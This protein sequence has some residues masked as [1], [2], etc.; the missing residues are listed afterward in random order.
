MDFPSKA[1][2]LRTI[3]RKNLRGIDINPTA[4]HIACFSL[5][6]AYL[7][8]FDPRSIR[9]HCKT[10]G[11]F[12]PNLI[13]SNKSTQPKGR[14]EHIP[15][16]TEA[17]FLT[18]ET[19]E[20]GAYD[21]IISNPPW[22][23]GNSESLGRRF[24]EVAPRHLKNAAHGGF[25]LPSRILLNNTAN[26]FQAKWLKHISIEKVV[27]LADF[28]NVLFD[29]AK[30]PCL[31]IRFG[32]SPMGDDDDWIEYV[33]PKA[34]GIEM[35]N[36]C[37]T[38]S[39]GDQ[40]WLSKKQL[41]QAIEQKKA[42]IFWKSH[43]WG[44][45]RDQK[46]LS[47][48]EGFPRLNDYAGTPKE[49]KKG[50]KRWSTGRGFEPF[51]AYQKGKPGETPQK[52]T[53]DLNDL[54]IYP[55][56]LEQFLFVPK[57]RN[58][59]TFGERLE[60]LGALKNELRR[61]PN[62][63][64]FEPPLI[65]FNNGYTHFAFIDYPVRFQHTLHVIAGKSAD[66]DALLFLT[67]YL[68]SK[69]GYYFIFHTSANIGTER[70][71]AQLQEV[72][73]IPFFLPDSEVASEVSGNTLK[74]CADIMRRLKA[75]L[76]RQWS[77]M[78]PEPSS[79][80]KLEADSWKGRVSQWEAFANKETEQVMERTINPLIYEYF[81]LIDQEIALVEDTYNIL[82]NSITPDNLGNSKGI[83]QSLSEIA[84]REY[85]DQLTKTLSGWMSPDSK[86][87]INAICRI[88]ETLGLACVELIQS[89]T[90]KP[91]SVEEF[92]EKEALSYLQLE[93]ASTEERGSLRY[94]RSIR[95]FDNGRIR[96]YKPARLGFWMRSTAIN[97][98]AALHAEI[99]G[100]GGVPR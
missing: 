55:K 39:P 42:T 71:K 43:F 60:E 1:A 91:I 65:L 35:R 11:K 61:K 53:W 45:P 73:K 25:L 80:F 9:Q 79:E 44:T 69:L 47:A 21:Y 24:M 34:Y 58:K 16:I 88:N 81:G 48:Y 82:R 96:I 27:I 94:L 23:R 89:K 49:V 3:F 15:V 93:E 28:S 8:Q 57:V 5:Y 20:N 37:L 36:G 30:C 29:Q 41:N 92:T 83:R 2:A 98:A 31:I 12:L 38:V 67:A 22:S 97:D 86:V 90:L 59:K 26:A 77:A 99:V 56:S 62:D 19:P 4:C 66:T 95:H 14:R 10:V 64:L 75:K 84:L 13:V 74:R 7:D 76:E 72:L 32:K 63:S 78:F 52:N 100:Y 54:F 6:L 18:H 85:A 46:F 40:K 51:Y 33:T 70:T 87:R 50:E 68:K 17:D